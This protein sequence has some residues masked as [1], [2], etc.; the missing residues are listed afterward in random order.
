MTGLLVCWMEKNHIQGKWGY[1]CFSCCC[2]CRA[3]DAASCR[4]SKRRS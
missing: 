3:R 2:C 4:S 1:C